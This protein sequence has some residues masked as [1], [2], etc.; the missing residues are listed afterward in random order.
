MKLLFF[1]KN[2]ISLSPFAL[3]SHKLSV[4]VAAPCLKMLIV[5]PNHM[6]FMQVYTHIFFALPYMGVCVVTFERGCLVL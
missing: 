2:V 5:L 1:G 3:V 6:I 4:T